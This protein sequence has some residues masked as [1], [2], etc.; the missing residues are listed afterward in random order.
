[1]KNTSDP[2]ISKPAIALGTHRFSVVCWEGKGFPAPRW[3]YIV[4]HFIRR[5]FKRSGREGWAK[6]GFASMHTQSKHFPTRKEAVLAGRQEA[7]ELLEF[8]TRKCAAVAKAT[9]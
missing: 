6:M 1:M 5:R 4:V 8:H 9:A 3:N 7:K 2:K